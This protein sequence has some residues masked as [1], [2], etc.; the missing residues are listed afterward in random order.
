MTKLSIDLDTRVGLQQFIAKHPKRAKEFLQTWLDGANELALMGFD[1]GL[2][3]E[4]A[5]QLQLRPADI[6]AGVLAGCLSEQLQNE[7]M[8]NILGKDLLPIAILTLK[9]LTVDGEELYADW[10]RWY[11]LDKHTQLNADTIAK[12]IAGIMKYARFLDFDKL[13]E[14]LESN[15][16][17]AFK[18][19]SSEQVKLLPFIP[20]LK[21]QR[22]HF[23]DA[24]VGKFMT[25]RNAGFFNCG[26]IA[27][28]EEQCPACGRD[29]LVHA[30]DGIHIYCRACN[31][32]FKIKGDVTDDCEV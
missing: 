1:M 5:N 24:R 11:S 9:G 6:L 14:A 22:E 20:A 19:M 23:G 30:K 16:L 7:K 2:L 15:Q 3:Q 27:T 17:I 32:G 10:R 13:S 29:D 31:A 28:D 12:V 21:Y 18:G 4:T 26:E 25:E 8:S